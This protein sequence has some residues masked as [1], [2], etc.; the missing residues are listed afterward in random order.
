MSIFEK[1]LD[2]FESLHLS[3]QNNP[4]VSLG[5]VRTA[6][7]LAGDQVSEQQVTKCALTLRCD[8]AK[9]SSSSCPYPILFG[10]GAAVTFFHSP[11]FAV[12]ATS[13]SHTFNSLVQ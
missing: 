2:D 1:F 9:S 12:M 7:K 5:V 8:F 4:Y 6:H 13:T 3:R 10:V 11:L